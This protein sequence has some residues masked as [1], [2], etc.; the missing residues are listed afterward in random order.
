MKNFQNDIDNLVSKILSEE[1]DSKVRKIMETKGEWKEIEM[2]EDLKGGQSKIDVAEPK[3]KI[4]A[5][6]FKKLRDAKS[7]KEE[8]EESTETVSEEEV[9]EVEETVL[10]FICK[11]S[12]KR[13]LILLFA[14]VTIAELAVSSPTEWSSIFT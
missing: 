11:L 12:T 1:I 4:T 8:V 13:L 7:H 2:N 5:A 3:G 9:S 6:D 10:P 14:S